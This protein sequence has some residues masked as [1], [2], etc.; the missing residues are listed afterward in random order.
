[1]HQPDQ[2]LRFGSAASL[3][4]VGSEQ[5]GAAKAA[6]PVVSTSLRMLVSVRTCCCAWFDWRSFLQAAG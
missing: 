6:P 5:A 4:A 2:Q 3:Q 1:L